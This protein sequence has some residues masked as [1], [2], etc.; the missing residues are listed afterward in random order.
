[1]TTKQLVNQLFNK[2]VSNLDCT[3]EQLELICQLKISF[4]TPTETQ[5]RLE[6]FRQMTTLKV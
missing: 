2:M 1:M 4:E 3:S 5:E 6:K